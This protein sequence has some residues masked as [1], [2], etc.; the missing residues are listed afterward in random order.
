MSARTL[1]TRV[2]ALA[3]AGVLGAAMLMTLVSRA[4]LSSLEQSI[5]EEHA[6]LATTVAAAVGREV[7]DDLRLL[8][9]AAATVEPEA[10]RTAL[11][12]VVHHGRLASSAFLATREGT[13]VLC[14]PSAECGPLP[15][16]ARALVRQSL[17]AQRPI[18]GGADAPDGAAFGVMPFRSQDP[19]APA[20][21]GIRIAPGERRLARVL[22]AGADAHVQFAIVDAGER[23]VAGSD[24]P[25][26]RVTSSAD[27]PGTTWTLRVAADAEPVAATFRRRS[28]ALT[29]ALASLALLL[30]WGVS[31]SVRQPLHGLTLAA[32]RIAGGNLEQPIDLRRASRG[33][34]EVRRLAGALER[35]RASLVTA[36]TVATANA[37]L[38]ERERVRQQLL[39]KLIAAQEDERKR[40]ARELHDETSQTLAALGMAVDLG[41]MDEVR[42]LAGRMHEELHR[43]IVDLRPSVLDDLGLADAIQWF[44]ER[45]LSS[46]GIAV[47]CEIAELEGRLA[48]EVETALF[49]A[50][51]EAIVNITRHAGAETVLI[52]LSA[53]QSGV[54]VE[55]EDDGVGFDP[56]GIAAEP[57]S[58][59]GIGL[60]GMRERI[61]IVGGTLRIDSEP[62]GGTHVVMTVPLARAVESRPQGVL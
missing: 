35:M 27:V 56:N 14:E 48:P 13:M 20:A 50:V 19:L 40:I 12:I 60:L 57:G 25:A 15:D 5:E 31:R 10:Q 54:T 28:V 58:L 53:D 36:M 43:L 38:E 3:G 47:R 17:E 24:L 41:R 7:A 8:S 11:A 55:I 59:R 46:R 33:G 21:G 23:L 6:R 49:R 18:V 51:Q 2:L 52:Q 42:R 4:S 37:R 34:G 26:R 22:V 62:G 30:A 44:A 39:R 9:A 61:E 32:E 16:S 1:Q 45:H 29:L